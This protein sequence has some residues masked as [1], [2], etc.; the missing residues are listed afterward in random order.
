MFGTLRRQARE[1]APLLAALYLP[2]T[3]LLLAGVIASYVKRLSFG[4]FTSDPTMVLGASPFTGAISNIGVLGWCATAT[5]CLFTWAVTRHRTGGG[6]GDAFLLIPGLLTASLM[7][8]DLFQIHEVLLPL[9]VGGPD[10]LLIVPYALIGLGWLVAFRRRI[11]KTEY[12]LLL[13]AAA[14][15][16]VVW[17]R[18][19]RLRRRAPAAE[20][21]VPSG[22][23]GRPTGARDHQ[24]GAQLT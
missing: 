5:L 11:L 20:T 15:T 14:T 17:P 19:S 9:Y 24:V 3:A 10:D 1:L 22:R 4:F 23:R 16:D 6:I 13:I 2:A 21:Y 7:A 8:D 12:L 18:S